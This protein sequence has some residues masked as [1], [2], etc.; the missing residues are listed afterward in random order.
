[1]AHRKKRRKSTKRQ[2]S[3]PWHVLVS[4]ANDAWE[5]GQEKEALRSWERA[6]QI[7][8]SPQLAA[9]LGELYFRRGVSLLI[10][11][12]D[13]ESLQGGLAD[14][15]Q[16]QTLTPDDTRLRYYLGLAH[17]LLGELDQAQAFYGQA[18][19]QEPYRRRAARQIAL[20]A[21]E[22][23]RDPSASPGWSLLE[24]DQQADL[25][26]AQQLLKPR[27]TFAISS[28]Q[29][30]AD[31]DDLHPLWT[32]LSVLGGRRVNKAKARDALEG[33]MVK[34][35]DGAPRFRLAQLYL[36]NLLWPDEP[37]AAARHWVDAA[38]EGAPTWAER[39]QAVGADLLAG[40]ALDAGDL[41]AAL[42]LAR[43]ALDHDPDQSV[44][45]EVMGHVECH[46]GNQAAQEDRWDEALQ[47]WE[48][49]YRLGYWDLSLVHN[50]A[51]G[52]EQL[53]RWADA[54]AAWREF[55]RR[56][57]RRADHPRA[58][59]LHQETLVR[60]QIASLYL[61]AGDETE[62]LQFY[63]QALDAQPEDESNAQLR[64]ELANLMAS[65]G[66]WWQAERVLQEGLRHH[67]DQVQ[68]LEQLG[69]LYQK[70]EQEKQAQATW[71]R[72]LK[73]APEHP[74]AREQMAIRL[75]HRAWN[76]ENV[77]QYDEAE[78]LYLQA[79]EYAPQDMGI[80]LDLAD[81]YH[82]RG[83]HDEAA[84]V[85]D[86]ILAQSPNDPQVIESVIC[87]W[88]SHDASTR[89]DAL[90]EQ[91]Q[92]DP[93]ERAGLYALVGMSYCQ[94]EQEQ[95]CAALIQQAVQIGQ[96]PH[97]TALQVSHTLL[98]HDLVSPAVTLLEQCLHEFPGE[99]V[100][101]LLLATAFAMEGQQGRAREVFRRARIAARQMGDREALPMLDEMES[102]VNSEPGLV[103]ALLDLMGIIH[104]I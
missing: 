98:K 54:A 20:I 4:K 70:L 84:R 77:E 8:P 97:L 86:E 32:A 19:E 33:A 96:V 34:E 62:A 37:L 51:L 43:T 76:H 104:E 5:R 103:L 68:L 63:R 42:S 50:Q 17:H 16:A 75:T 55:L 102:T 21:L 49:A 59:S 30:L 28:N 46:L 26:A 3:A 71:E 53:E 38:R 95:K 83:T 35:R 58:L 79:L 94:A 64:I 15:E 40:Y 22:Q 39:N 48:K 36:G 74:M 6:W 93:D 29:E 56:R 25:M 12:E 80:K 45:R 41:D 61:R 18:L 57:P 10:D 65:H 9:A 81:M 69:L 52:Y 44:Y 99:P 23:G 100:A 101:S 92:G 60:R 67:P 31:E 78:A 14:L 89:A 47:H 66:R 88:V 72:V 73:V 13:R 87:F 90:L 7:K 11:A 27:R 24:G 91:A 2:S 82:V 1:M 85:I